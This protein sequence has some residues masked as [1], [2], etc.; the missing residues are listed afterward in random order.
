MLTLQKITCFSGFI[1]GCTSCKIVMHCLRPKCQSFALSRVN[2]RA[3]TFT[4]LYIVSFIV[5]VTHC[6]TY[7]YSTNDMSYDEAQKVCQSK[8]TDLVA[9]Q[10]KKEIEYLQENIPTN[11]NY[12]WIGIRKINGAWT[13]VG[14]NKTLTKEAENWG[15]NEPN[16]KKNNEDCVEIY[17]GRAKD[18]G[19]WNDDSCK[20]RKRALCYTASCNSTSCSG[21]GECIETINNFTCAC[22]AGFYGDLCQ[23]VVQ[24]PHLLNEPLTYMN[25]SHPWG[26]FS[27]ESLCHFECLDGFFLNGMDNIQCLSSGNWSEATPHCSVEQCPHLLN[28]PLAYMNCS[29]P[30]GNFSFESLC[31]FKCLDG[32][33]LNGMDTI[34]CLSSGNWSEATPHCSAVQCPHLVTEPSTYMNCS[35]SWGNFSFKSQ[36]Q[37][38]CLDGFFLNGTDNIQCLS[39]GNWSEAPPHCSENLNLLH[40]QIDHQRPVFIL[41]LATAASALTLALALWLI[42]RRFKKAKKDRKNAY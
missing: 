24:C 17:I 23:H 33:F 35:H 41:G 28:E 14:T 39:T 6:W 11:K 9:I 12:Y 16:N 10:N 7:H 27:F 21:H 38:E 13:W 22:H 26:N 8:F 25:C 30:W 32:F 3:A 1:K 29:H 5:S 18:S 20:K 2:H 19:K 40:S 34:Q 4:V 37:F 42:H 31:H 15:E 36:C